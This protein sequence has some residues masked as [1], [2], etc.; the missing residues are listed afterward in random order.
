[1]WFIIC[2]LPPFYFYSLLDF[3]P[4]Q[5]IDFV[6]CIGAGVFSLDPR[7]GF[8]TFVVLEFG[9]DEQSLSI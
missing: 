8:A 6:T 9:V 7:I 2:F 1:M 3:K 4:D 5:G